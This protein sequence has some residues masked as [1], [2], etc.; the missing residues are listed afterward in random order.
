MTKITMTQLLEAGVHFGHRAR[1]WNP[2]MSQYIYGVRNKLH[3]INLEK[4]LP[5]FEDMLKTVKDITARRGKILF[6][7]TK[8]QASSIIREEANRCGM[9]YVDY[10]WLGG[11]L[12]NYKTIRQSIRRLKQLEQ[13]FAD[14]AFEG[15]TKKERLNLIRERTKLDNALSGIKD[16]GGLP[17]ALFVID[18]NVERIAIQ[19]ANRLRIPVL[20]VVDTNCDPA[21]VDCLVPGND[22]AMRAIRLYCQA[23]ADVVLAEQAKLEIDQVKQG[24]AEDAKKTVKKVITKRTKTVVKQKEGDDAE[25]GVEVAEAAVAATSAKKRTAAKKPAA[26]KEA[27]EVEATADAEKTETETEE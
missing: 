5:M 16:M 18:V 1:Y 3:I 17:D 15:L 11:M 24:G 19:E 13:Q 7:G 25:A 8:Y 12:T 2:K 27:A 20:G 10:R 23:V 9:P 21:G 14:E 6:V 4:T 26:K 22:D